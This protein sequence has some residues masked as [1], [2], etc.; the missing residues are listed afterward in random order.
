MTLIVINAFGRKRNYSSSIVVQMGWKLEEET[1]S[2]S[3]TSK[4]PTANTT[5][6]KPTRKQNITLKKETLKRE[7]L[8]YF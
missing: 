5:V 4:R 1:Y 3:D 2:H 6:K 8:I 7:T